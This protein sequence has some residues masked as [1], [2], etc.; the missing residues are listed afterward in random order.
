MGR[1]DRNAAE[2]DLFGIFHFEKYLAIYILWY[3]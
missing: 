3:F 1:D 2:V